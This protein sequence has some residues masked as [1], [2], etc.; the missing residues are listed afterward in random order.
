MIKITIHTIGEN[1]MPVCEYHCK[2]CDLLFE[3]LFFKGDDQQVHC[4][5]CGDPQMSKRLSAD[6]FMDRTGIG[7]CAADVPKDFS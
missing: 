2:T 6:S 7:V 1:H 3:R 5:R 4:P